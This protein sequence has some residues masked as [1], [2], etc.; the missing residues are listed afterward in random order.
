[1]PSGSRPLLSA[2]DPTPTTPDR[3]APP[4]HRSRAKRHTGRAPPAEALR[5]HRP[6]PRTGEPDV[7]REESRFTKRTHF[8]NAKRAALR[9]V[10]DPDSSGKPFRLLKAAAGPT[11]PR[12]NASLRNEPISPPQRHNVLWSS[13]LRLIIDRGKTV[14]LYPPPLLVLGMITTVTILFGTRVAWR[15]LFPGIEGGGRTRIAGIRCNLMGQVLCRTGLL[16]TPFH[17]WAASWSNVFLRR[18]MWW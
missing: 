2:E 17:P 5:T 18:R 10:A 3:P 4:I 14:P 1:M 9:N 16:P 15:R 6:A 13:N 12:E 11:H 8:P 7:Q